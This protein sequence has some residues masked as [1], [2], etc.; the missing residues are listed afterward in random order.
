MNN[1]CIITNK[2]N[3]NE[4]L[5]KHDVYQILKTMA[6]K[7]ENLE[8]EVKQLKKRSSNIYSNVLEIL[9]SDYKPILDFTSWIN[10]EII[11]QIPH[12]LEDVFI[13]DLITA[14]KKMF[15]N[16]NLTARKICLPFCYTYKNREHKYFIYENSQ[17]KIVE[18]KKLNYFIK[19]IMCEFTN[20]FNKTWCEENKENILKNDKYKDMFEE[21]Q[22][23]VLGGNVKPEILCNKIKDILKKNFVIKFK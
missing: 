11:V 5:E 8:E 3:Q 14:I 4:I 7:I 13:T 20:V 9:N 6:K 18:E 10:Q 16:Y 22:K 21:Y 19:F 15:E 12:Y 2:Q 17:W 1:S 23:K